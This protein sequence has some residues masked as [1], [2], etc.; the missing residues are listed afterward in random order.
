MALVANLVWESGGN[1]RVGPHKIMFEARGDKS[2]KDGLF[3]S[4]GAG[5]WNENVGRYQALLEFDKG[6]GGL[7][8]WPI[9]PMTQLKFLHRE[10]L[11]TERRAANKLREAKTIEEAVEAA[12]G[13]WRPSIPHAD[14]RLAIAQSLI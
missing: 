11:T 13:V 5:Q 6:M 9:P 1:R 4:H 14:K 12:I 2:P 8:A 3:K 10:L 7:G